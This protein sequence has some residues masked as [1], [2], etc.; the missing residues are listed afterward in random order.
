VR[1]GRR[2]GIEYDLGQAFA[3]AQIDEDEVAVVAPIGNPAEQH[4]FAADVSGAQGAA[5]VSSFEFVDK[6]SHGVSFS[7]AHGPAVLLGGRS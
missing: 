1:V 3:V 5:V 2:I 4:H 6:A 7:L